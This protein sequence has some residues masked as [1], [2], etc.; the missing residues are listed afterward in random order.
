[1]LVKSVYFDIG[2]FVTE[3]ALDLPCF[4][5]QF[6]ESNQILI[7]CQNT[8]TLFYHVFCDTQ[9]LFFISNV[10][11]YEALT[12]LGLA[13]E[14]GDMALHLARLAKECG[15]DGVVC[16]AQESVAVRGA[17]GE[18][19]LRLTPGIRPRG[20]AAQDQA[21]VVTPAQAL[22]DGSTWLVVGRPITRAEDPAAAADAILAEMAEA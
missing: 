5:H 19:F 20:G 8:Q 16:S 17:C 21:R 2:Y 7:A 13:T 15:C 10:I 9:F 14:P 6:A 12:R 4:V 3:F 22:R 11:A 1:M 18:D